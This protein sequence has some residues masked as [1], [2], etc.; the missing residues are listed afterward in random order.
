M[1]SNSNS[2]SS[3]M[4]CTSIKL[5]RI[6]GF[7]SRYQYRQ[8]HLQLCTTRV[9]GCS[10][11]RRWVDYTIITK[12]QPKPWKGNHEGGVKQTWRHEVKVSKFL[13]YLSRFLSTKRGER[14]MPLPLSIG[15]CI[16]I[17]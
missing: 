4:S 16:N 13:R 7:N 10:R 3:R 11:F 15:I 8:C 5:D 1:R 14:L 17:G 9:T 12:E 6:K 2:F